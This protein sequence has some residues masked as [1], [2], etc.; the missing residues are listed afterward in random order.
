MKLKK[1]KILIVEDEL[2]TASDIEENL[3]SLG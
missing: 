2:L 1:V 3:I